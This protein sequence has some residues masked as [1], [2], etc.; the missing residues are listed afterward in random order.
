[1]LAAAVPERPRHAGT[2]Y[3]N[4]PAPHQTES[5]MPSRTATAPQTTTEPASASGGR[6]RRGVN[7]EGL[8][9]GKRSTRTILWI[10]LAAALVLYGFPFLYLLFTSFKTPIDTIA[11]PPTILPKEW[12]LDNYINA[13]GRNGVPASFINSIQTAVISTLLSLIL[14]VPAAYG[15]TRYKTASGRVFIMAALV[16]RMVPRSPSAS[17]WRP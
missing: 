1:M 16:T 5:I 12:T 10:L 7:R 2:A 15:I 9:A 6:K 14:A 13:L 11:V 8:E 17:R 4:A 3:R